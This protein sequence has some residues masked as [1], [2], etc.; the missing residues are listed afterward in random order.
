MVISSSSLIVYIVFGPQICKQVPEIDVSVEREEGH[1]HA[2]CCSEAGSLHIAQYVA[3]LIK[4]HL[5]D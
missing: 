5:A 4:N 1:K 3:S 2:F